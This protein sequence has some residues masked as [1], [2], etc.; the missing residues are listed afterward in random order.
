METNVPVYEKLMKLLVYPF[1]AEKL[2]V[3]LQE[4]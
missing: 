2:N 1:G 4:G 3:K